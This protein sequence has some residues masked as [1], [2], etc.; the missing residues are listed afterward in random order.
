MSHGLILINTGPGKGKTTAALGA[1]LR[2]AGHGRQVVIM[3]FVKSRESGEHKALSVLPNIKFRLLGRGLIMGKPSEA[4]RLSARQGWDDCLKLAESGACDL[5]ILDEICVAMRY[6]LISPAEVVDFLKN[7][8][9]SLHLILTGRD[10]PPE[11][12]D[13]A[14]T[15]TFMDAVKHHFAAGIG[16]QPGIED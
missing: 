2:A 3:Q 16:A 9:P 11:I 8:P 15:V 4:D 12:L 13:L 14:D 1:A 5:L 7:K 10:C 6:G